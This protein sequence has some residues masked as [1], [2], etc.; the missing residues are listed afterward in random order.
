MAH[1][2]RFMGK[3]RKNLVSFLLDRTGS[4]GPIWEATI[5][6]FNEFLNGQVTQDDYKTVWNLTVFDSESIDLIRE[7]VKGKD[8]EPLHPVE[9]GIYPRSMTPLHDAIAQTVLA[10]DKLAGDYDGTIFVILTDGMENHSKEYNLDAVKKLIREREDTFNWQII[11]LGANMDAYQV[12]L[13]YGI[14]KGQTVSWAATPESVEATY[15]VVTA[16]A[17]SYGPSGQSISTH[18]DTKS[19]EAHEKEDE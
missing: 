12:G 7:G 10:T 9:S 15:G 13:D 4:M 14:Q 6:G 11:F 5:D 19:G 8:M 3:K 16:T 17:R 1:E 18:Y 2:R